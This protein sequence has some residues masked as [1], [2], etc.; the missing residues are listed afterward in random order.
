MF[1]L[2]G[3]SFNTCIYWWLCHVS[4]VFFICYSFIMEQTSCLL[5][6]CIMCQSCYFQ[7]L[8]IYLYVRGLYT[9]F[10]RYYL[11]TNNL[12]Y[13]ASLIVQLF[14]K[15]CIIF[16]RFE[17]GLSTLGVGT[18]IQ[19]WPHLM[20]DALVYQER[21]AKVTAEEVE[22]W[23][24]PILS[25]K[26]SNRYKA[27]IE[28]LTL[29]R[30]L[31]IELEGMSDT[32]Y[33]LQRLLPCNIEKFCKVMLLQNFQNFIFPNPW[34]YRLLFTVNS[35]YWEK[36][37]I[38]IKK[39]VL[40]F[41]CGFI[42]SYEHLQSNMYMCMKSL[43]QLRIKNWILYTCLVMFM[44]L[45]C[46]S[47]RPGKTARLLN[48]FT[49]PSS[50]RFSA[51]T[52]TCIRPPCWLWQRSKRAISLWQYLRQCV[53]SSNGTFLATVPRERY[54]CHKEGDDFHCRMKTAQILIFPWINGNAFFLNRTGL[55]MR[56]DH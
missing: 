38:P 4:D 18:A 8:Y 16:Y 5:L 43:F 33:C 14:T 19:T 46:R 24:R 31:L 28:T 12:P 35:L 32:S 17:E 54:W 7:V 48:R 25:E 37:D 27:E 23:F 29:W 34:C 51:T 2:W 52:I 21:Q 20:E 40:C 56:I 22:T 41:H 44:Y 15:V 45:H 26:G 36:K 47:R 6:V 1:P 13:N 11:C 49:S 10:L 30:D 53:A 3:A 55:K 9:M 50:T 39:I 42:C